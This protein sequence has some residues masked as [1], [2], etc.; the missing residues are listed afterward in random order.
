MQSQEAD[1]SPEEFQR[2][3][4]DYNVKYV[5]DFCDEFF[6]TSKAEAWFQDRYNPVRRREIEAEAAAWGAVESAKMKADLEANASLVVQGVCLDKSAIPATPPK[7]DK[8]QAQLPVRHRPADESNP[9][10]IPGKHFSGHEYRALFVTGLHASCTLSALKA[11]FASA[12]SDKGLDF[13]PERVV[14]SQ[15]MWTT[16]G[17]PSRYERY[18]IIYIITQYILVDR[19]SDFLLTLYSFTEK[20]GLFCLHSSHCSRCWKVSLSSAFQVC[21]CNH[22]FVCVPYGAISF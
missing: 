18:A 20:D 22:T 21:G 7:R 3:Y 2:K 14:L 8:D 6:H 19:I 9:A 10:D 11:A 15:P 16:K 4:D 5:E 1:C 12:L 13:A 17:Q